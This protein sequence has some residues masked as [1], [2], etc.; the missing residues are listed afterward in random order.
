M[1]SST[2]FLILLRRSKSPQIKFGLVV[3]SGT[4]RQAPWARDPDV[5]QR[6]ALGLTMHDD[7]ATRLIATK[8]LEMA[9]RGI[10]DP[11]TISQL[12]LKEFN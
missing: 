10:T 8:I 11:A 2:D 5:Q 7:P 12:V 4:R 9:Q 3:P 6:A 1:A